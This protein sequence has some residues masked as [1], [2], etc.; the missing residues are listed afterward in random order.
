MHQAL[1]RVNAA[2]M[3]DPYETREFIQDVVFLGRTRTEAQI[4]CS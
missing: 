1:H 3:L 2:N 4:I